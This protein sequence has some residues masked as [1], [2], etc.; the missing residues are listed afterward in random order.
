M[1]TAEIGK[2]RVEHTCC[3]LSLVTVLDKLTFL[4]TALL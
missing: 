3:F 1:L 4:P 2:K